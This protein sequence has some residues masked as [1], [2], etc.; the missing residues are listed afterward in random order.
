M[1]SQTSSLF[2]FAGIIAAFTIVLVSIVLSGCTAT[3][4]GETPTQGVLPTEQPPPTQPPASPA[5]PEVTQV[6]VR[7]DL[8]YARYTLDGETHPLLLDLYLP[9]QT[10]GQSLPLLLYIHG[11]GWIEGSKDGC[12]GEAFARNGYAVACVDYRLAS[13]PQGCPAELLFPAQIHDVKAAVRWLRQHADQYGLDPARFGALGDSSGGHLAALLGTSAGVPELEGTEN[14]G[15]SDAVQAVADWFGPVD[16]TQGPVVFEDDP[17][18]TNFDDLNRTYGGEETPYFYWTLAWGTFLGGSLS[19]P[20]VL[21]RATQA[22]PLTYVDANDPPFLI[23][24]GEADDM[25]PIEQ[26]EALAAALNEAGV[27]VTFIRVPNAGH[28]FYTPEETAMP[29]FLEPTLEFFDRHLKKAGGQSSSGKGGPLT[30]DETWSGEILVTDTVTVPEGV[31]LT[32]EPGTVVRFRHYRGYK[33]GKAGLFVSGGTVKA[34]GTPEQQIWFT[35]DAEEPINGDWAGISLVDTDD[36]EFDYVIVEYAEIGIEQFHSQADVSNSI[37]RWNNSEG[38]YAEMSRAVFENNTI[39]GNAYHAIALENFN[40]YIEIRNNLINGAGQQCVHIENSNALVEGNYFQNFDV[41]EA[42][43]EK[44]VSVMGA[45]EVTIRRNKFETHGEGQPFMVE[46]DTPPVVEDNDFGDGHIAP[47][48]FD[49]EDVKVTELGYLPGDPQD[50]YLY[51]FDE[52]D[53]TRR[54]VGRYG[55]GLGLGWAAAYADGGVWRFDAA[56]TFVK[57]DPETGMDYTNEY[58]NPEHIAAHGLA[59]DGEY[60][61]ANDHWRRQIVKFRL[62]TEDDYPDVGS[63]KAIKIVAAFDIPEKELGGGSGIATDGEY[64]YIPGE[65]GLYQL[66]KSGNIVGEIAFEGPIGP[67]ITWD[68]TYFWSAGGNGIQ[69]WTKDGQPA[70]MIYAPAV[71]TWDLAWGDGYLWTINRTCEKW[72]D[73]KVF[74]VEVLDLTPLPPTP[75]PLSAAERGEGAT[76]VRGEVTIDAG[77]TGEPSSPYLYGAF[78]EH[79]GRCIYGGVWAEMFQDRKFYYPVDYYFPWG[80]QKHKSPWRANE[81]D[82]VVVMDTEHAYVGE[83]TSRI[84]LDGQKPRGIVQS[85]LGL[86]KGKEYEGYVILADHGSVEVQVSLVWGSGPDERQVV[87]LGAVSEEYTRV[88]FRFTAG[89]DTDD[90]RLEIVGRGEGTFYVGAVSLMPADNIQGMRADV[91]ALLKEIGFTVYRWPGGLFVNDYQWRQATGDRDK[92]PPRLNHAYWSEMVESNDFGL[93]EFMTL[94]QVVGAEPYVVVSSSGDNDDRMAA[95]EVEYLNGA[96]DT[97]MGA[98]RAA[99]GHPEPYNVEFWGVGNEMWDMPLKEYIER[100]NRIAEA[101]R[102]VD[103]SIKLIAVGGIGFEGL[104]EGGDWSQGMLTYSADYMDLI[105]EHIYGGSNPDLLAHVLGIAEGVRG[106]VEAHRGYRR[107]LASLEGKDIRLAL[108]EW[109]YFWGDR[110]EIYGEAGPRYYFKDALGVAVGLHEMFRNSDMIFMAN[111]HP[112][113]VHGQVKTTQTDAA[114][115]TTALVWELYRHHFGTLPLT[116]NGDTG[117]LDVAAAWSEDHQTLTIAVVNP[118]EYEHTLALRLQNAQLRGAAQLWIV[119][120]SDP[121]AYNE[122]GQPPRVT[123]EEKQLSGIAN[124]LSVPPL[125]ISLYELPASE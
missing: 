27:E 105:S 38:L 100:H 120:N 60:F 62:G 10:A 125:S 15:A 82:T 111:T 96:A 20:A 65:T 25:V 11:G 83:H 43:P 112:V 5:P 21:G 124:D 56:G 63:G 29:E 14:P 102:A 68:G 117:P 116:V 34:I 71:E 66:D 123:I 45:S 80:E 57:I 59:Y 12:P 55:E 73:A 31:T 121:M 35:S 106:A 85:G 110:Y 109:N 49:Y 77:Q 33:E 70:G 16:I 88:P 17:C 91:I 39:Y 119:A 40:E 30:H 44:V 50:R 99:N 108:D 26:S 94:C 74:Q 19:D 114:M 67:A 81:F 52:V 101:M 51:V 97:P 87:P 115:E 79:Q 58:A 76:G 103:P 90:G 8:E 118:T 22:T 86:K 2:R 46:S 24:H 107:Q 6:T 78:I 104:P 23:I 54:V 7:R 4:G 36:S 48:V 37:L 47:P 28:G 61:W 89:A 72:N 93:D 84:D 42:A 41:S 13:A 98:L 69:R 92:R 122:P 64:L 95:E 1:K 53:E 18:T 32:I 9:E 75:S 113:N 3:L